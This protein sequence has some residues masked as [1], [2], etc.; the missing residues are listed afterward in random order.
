MTIGNFTAKV[1]SV[2]ADG[3]SLTLDQTP[4]TSL[5]EGTPVL[6]DV[7]AMRSAED[8]DPKANKL[9][10]FAISPTPG[11][12][13]FQE[14][15]LSSKKDKNAECTGEYD[16]VLQDYKNYFTD[17]L[18]GIS[19]NELEELVPLSMSPASTAPLDNQI[20]RISAADLGRLM[21]SGG[22][23]KRP[24]GILIVD[25]DVTH[26]VHIQFD[27]FIYFRGSVKKFNG[28][29]DVDGAIAVRGTSDSNGN[30]NINYDAVKLRKL[31]LNATGGMPQ[32]KADSSTWRQR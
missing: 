5:T 26:P 2:G 19:D 15:K 3:R 10:D 21:G 22:S 12:P 29:M 14:C 27:G 20:R 11:A 1:V 16:Q 32:F 24:S 6:R 17:Y 8:I 7:K 25:G 23:G 31:M 9:G 4:G 18:L 30:M 28:N 13:R